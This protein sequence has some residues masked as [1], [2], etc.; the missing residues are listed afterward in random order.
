MGVPYGPGCR[1]SSSEA[2]A[3]SPRFDQIVIIT[4]LIG[5]GKKKNMYQLLIFAEIN[6]KK[7]TQSG[8]TRT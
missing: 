3:F 8:A 6:L 1:N 4:N 2:L 5:D 7:T